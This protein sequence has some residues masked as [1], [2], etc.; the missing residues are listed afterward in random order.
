MEN[1]DKKMWVAIFIWIISVIAIISRIDK[2][3]VQSIL[4]CRSIVYC[5]I[6]SF[7]GKFL[8]ASFIG[9]ILSGMACLA[10]KKWRNAYSHILG[11]IFIN[12]LFFVF[13]ISD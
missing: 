4:E 8:G 3:F 5:A 12:L 9:I 6:P 10:T 1:Q 7:I 2:N 13:L 11:A